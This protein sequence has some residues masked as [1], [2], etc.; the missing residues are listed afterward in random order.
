MK[1]NLLPCPFCG[2]KATLLAVGKYGSAAI[3]CARCKIHTEESNICEE[4]ADASNMAAFV[5]VWNRRAEV[6]P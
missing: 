5:S 4:D 2:E 1:L 3:G 6:K